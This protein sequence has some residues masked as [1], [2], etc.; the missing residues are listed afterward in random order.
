MSATSP[1]QLLTGTKKKPTANIV[2]QTMPL[3]ITVI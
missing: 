1:I 3:P 2:T